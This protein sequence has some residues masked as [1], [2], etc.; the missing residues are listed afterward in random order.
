[1]VFI[2]AS[3]IGLILGVVFFTLRFV[4]GD[5]FWFAAQASAVVGVGFT[6]LTLLVIAAVDMLLIPVRRS[7]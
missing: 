5:P 7:R 4:I 3:L 6:L 2:A 1:M